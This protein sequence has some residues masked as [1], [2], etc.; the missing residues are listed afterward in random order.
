VPARIRARPRPHSSHRRFASCD[1]GLLED[2]SR[3]SSSPGALIG[4]GGLLSALRSF[5]DAIFA[6]LAILRL[7]LQADWEMHG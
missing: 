6:A 2:C 1:D 4:S 7:A 3:G 5:C